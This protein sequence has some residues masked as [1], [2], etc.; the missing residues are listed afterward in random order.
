MKQLVKILVKLIAWFLVSVWF[1]K[2]TGKSF[3]CIFND[4]SEVIYDLFLNLRISALLDS[5]KSKYK[6]GG[7]VPQLSKDSAPKI[8]SITFTPKMPPQIKYTFDKYGLNIH[9]LLYNDNTLSLILKAS[10]KKCKLT[11][12]VSILAGRDLYEP[13][14]TKNHAH[15]IREQCECYNIN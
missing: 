8:S 5:S 11:S 4:M 9:D 6:T 3:F 10:C 12:K 14:F 13:D 15:A 1:V 7:I 2:K